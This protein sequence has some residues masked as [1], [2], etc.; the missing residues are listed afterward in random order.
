MVRCL[1]KLPGT[2]LP[3][4]ASFANFMIGN[5][6][7]NRRL[8][9]LVDEARLSSVERSADWV[10]A[11]YDNQKSS[12]SLVSYGAVSGPRT[13]IS[14]LY[15]SGTFGSAFSYTLSAS[16]TS[17]IASRVFY[18]LPA[19]LD[20]NDNGQITGT[21]TISG[22]FSVSLV[23]NYSNDDGDDTDSDSLND[24]L[25]SSDPT[26]SDAILLTLDIATLA[27]TINTLA[28]TSVGATSAYF[29][30][31]VT[32]TG[33]ENPE[34]TIYYGSNDGAS[35]AGSWGSSLNIGTQEAGVFSILIG[36]L[37]PSSTYYY[38]VRAA[39]S[40]EANGV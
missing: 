11:E 1:P 5:D 28:A 25:G 3:D 7:D 34:V 40:A 27:P 17:D 37:L 12:Q 15:A 30:G 6:H 32:S 14:P 19:G 29:E 23:V 20:F 38:R 4:T 24:K 21:P 39:N 36:D 9:G 26:S 22:E 16:D 35:T 8:S 13:I 33:G 31:N 10:K 2:Q 18:G